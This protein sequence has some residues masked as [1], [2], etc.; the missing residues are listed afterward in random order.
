MMDDVDAPV[1]Q[2][3]VEKPDGPDNV[4]GLVHIAVVPDVIVSLEE[5]TGF[6]G[7]EFTV[8]TTAVRELSHVPLLIEA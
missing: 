4:T 2:L 6:V 8:A 3:Y 5:I 7:M 1:D